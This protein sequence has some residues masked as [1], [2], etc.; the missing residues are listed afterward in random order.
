[1]RTA[2]AAPIAVIDHEA[3]LTDREHH[4]VGGQ[5]RR[6]D[7]ADDDARE[8]EG[9]G[10]HA[11]LQRDGP[12]QEV[13]LAEVGAVDASPEEALGV[14]PILPARE[15]DHHHRH[16]H[17]Y[18]RG[19]RAESRSRQ[20]QFGRAELAV[21]QHPVAEDIEDVAADEHPHRE[22]G[23]GDAV[24]KLLED[25]EEADEGEGGEQHEVVGLDQRQQFRGLAQVVDGEVEAPHHADDEGGEQQV[26]TDGV[27]HH[28]ADALRLLLA[29]ERADGG[30]DGIGEAEG[31]DDDEVDDIV[32]E[33]RGSQF[34]GGMVADHQRVGKG[35]D[36]RAE[37]SHHDGDA[38][39]R[40][41]LVIGSITM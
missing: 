32:D 6:A 10:L 9:R 25:V 41:R 3:H 30:R 2:A 33:G 13:E 16:R 29:V 35:E 26:G 24:G 15:E 20:S 38:E 34:A 22:R 27:A 11:H 40:Q 31:E 23:V 39:H 28:L 18:A 21:D 7:P 8:A 36:D 19:Q 12:S 17:D 37:L 4:L 1:M 5:G 14:G